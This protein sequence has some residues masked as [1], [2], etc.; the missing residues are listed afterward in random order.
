MVLFAVGTPAVTGT[1]SFTNTTR[2]SRV[3]VQI[4]SAI[5]RARYSHFLHATR[6]RDTLWQR[7]KVV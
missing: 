5:A 6:G 3:Y 4:V 7:H 1:C 2:W